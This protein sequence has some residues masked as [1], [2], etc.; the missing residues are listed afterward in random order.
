MHFHPGSSPA[1]PQPSAFWMP[2]SAHF[3]LIPYWADVLG[4]SAFHAF[5][6]SKRGGEL[7]CAHAGERVKISGKAALYM[8]GTITI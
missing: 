8:E 6:V 7:F 4:K 5:Q 3:V 1:I 2:G